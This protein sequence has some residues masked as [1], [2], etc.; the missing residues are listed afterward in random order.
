MPAVVLYVLKPMD[1]MVVESVVV[2]YVMK[3]MDKKREKNT[4]V[5]HDRARPSQSPGL[6]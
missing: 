1:I 4:K 3:P 6:A 2:G 5:C